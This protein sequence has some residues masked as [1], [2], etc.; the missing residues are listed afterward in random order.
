MNLVHLLLNAARRQPQRPALA[1]GKTAVSS[2]GDLASRVQR[3]SSGMR[4]KLSLV[5][6]TASRWR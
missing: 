4:D 1:L 2:Y 6:A 3:L 5:P